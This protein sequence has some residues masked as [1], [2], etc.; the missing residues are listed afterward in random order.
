MPRAQSVAKAREL[1]STAQT[2]A[3][4]KIQ[5]G[6]AIETVQ[7]MLHGEIVVDPA[8]MNA[9]V[10]AARLLLSKALPDLSSV[11]MT[12]AEGGPLTITINKIT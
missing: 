9:R 6:R 1:L 4:T 10:A 5:V 8:T 12:G 11:E 3:R 2:E 7:K